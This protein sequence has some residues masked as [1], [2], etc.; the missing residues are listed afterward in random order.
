MD[1]VVG[2]VTTFYARDSQ[3]KPSCG[4]WNLW[5]KQITSTTKLIGFEKLI[6]ETLEKH[7]ECVQS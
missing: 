1:Y 6:I 4:H 5:S 3:F 2:K 7:S